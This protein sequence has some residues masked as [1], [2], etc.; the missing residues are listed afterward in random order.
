MCDPQEFVPPL[1]QGA[2]D[3][4]WQAEKYDPDGFDPEVIAEPGISFDEEEEELEYHDDP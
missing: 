4:D 1:A 3:D 2:D